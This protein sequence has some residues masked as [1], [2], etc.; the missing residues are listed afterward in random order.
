MQHMRETIAFS[1]AWFWQ[2]CYPLARIALSGPEAFES[3]LVTEV[4]AI[5][6][7]FTVNHIQQSADETHEHVQGSIHSL[8]ILSPSPDGHM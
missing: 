3:P 5:A 7:P 2:S 8:F 4:A 1:Q 6:A